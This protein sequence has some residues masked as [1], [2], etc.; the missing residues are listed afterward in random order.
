MIIWSPPTK[1]GFDLGVCVLKG[2]FDAAV[3]PASAAVNRGRLLPN[4]D[5]R[6]VVRRAGTTVVAELAEGMCELAA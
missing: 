6:C 3:G 1:Y 2:V 5:G 4:C